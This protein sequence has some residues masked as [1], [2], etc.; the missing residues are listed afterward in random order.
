MDKIMTLRDT[1]ANDIKI[2]SY[3]L[4]I[5]E[6]L[7]KILKKRLTK[8]EFKLYK[9][10]SED[11]TKEYICKELNL[12]DKRYEEISITVLKKINYEKLKSELSLKD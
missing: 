5:E 9:F 7:I 6:E 12:D 4:K 3:E 1:L 10:K 8:K 2:L 11:N